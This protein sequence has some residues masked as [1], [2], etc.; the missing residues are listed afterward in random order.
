MRACVCMCVCARVRAFDV[1]AH[2]CFCAGACASSIDTISLGSLAC[3]G[4]QLSRLRELEAGLETARARLA[5]K[6]EK[7]AVLQG[8]LEEVNR[9][10]SLVKKE[11]SQQ[12]QESEKHA[13]SLRKQMDAE[14]S[15]MAEAI[16]SESRE[17][18]ACLQSTVL[19]ERERCAA[20]EAEKHACAGLLFEREAELAAVRRELDGCQQELGVYGQYIKNELEAAAS[21]A[22]A[23]AAAAG[24]EEAREEVEQLRSSLLLAQRE[25]AELRECARDLD[26]LRQAL[27]AAESELAVLREC[28]SQTR[29]LSARLGISRH[30]DV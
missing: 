19:W 18:E 12:L 7:V 8:S 30:L 14:Y 15:G 29:L 4:G 6:E 22:A 3:A 2:S 24:R 13:C 25:L 20:L 5:L 27:E 26:P 17:R 28:M 9:R 23:T 1:C 11:A 21:T 10:V 16:K